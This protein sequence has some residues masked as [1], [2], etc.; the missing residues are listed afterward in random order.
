MHGD[1]LVR[2]PMQRMISG[3]GRASDY[4]RGNGLKT[5]SKIIGRIL[6]PPL[7]PAERLRRGQAAEPAG[8]DSGW[9]VLVSV[10]LR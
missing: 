1:G 7:P 5:V 3:F 2:N 9:P 10:T 6:S 4:L 8:D